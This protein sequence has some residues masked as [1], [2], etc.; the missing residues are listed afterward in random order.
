MLPTHT[1]STEET[2]SDEAPPQ[3]NAHQTPALYLIGPKIQKVPELLRKEDSSRGAYDPKV[4]SFGPYHHG[5]LELKT[6][7]EVKQFTLQLF[8][9]GGNQPPQFYFTKILELIS[10]V[11]YCYVEG[12]TEQYSDEQLAQ[13]MLLD[14]SFLIY[15][16]NVGEQNPLHRLLIYSYLGNLVNLLVNRDI[17]LMEN[18]IPFHILMLLINLRYNNGEESVSKFLHRSIWGQYKHEQIQN[19]REQ[20]SQPLHLFDAFRR[21]LVWDFIPESQATTDEKETDS[22]KRHKTFR[23]AKDLKAKGIHFEPSRNKSLKAINF[24]SFTFYGQLQLPT[25]F[26]SDLSKVF[27][28]NMIAYELCPNNLVDTTV[29]S[30]I[31]FMKS[32]IDSPP[33]VKELREKRILLTSLGSDEDVVKLYKGLDTYG[34]PSVYSYMEVKQRIQEHYDSKGRTWMAQLFHN[35]FSSP[36]SIIA[37]IAAVI[38]LVLTAVQTCFTVKPK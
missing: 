2:S 20:Q 16:M 35:Y 25:W 13:M 12:S 6:C 9:E 14:S 23:S 26:V 4:V 32:L 17:F 15:F 1:D 31:D 29:I 22:K 37:W 34:M 18:Q 11:R 5:K 19:I 21:V 8:V 30:Y 36:W 28:P 38:V 24:D 33:D 27:F 10:Y 3:T 7:E